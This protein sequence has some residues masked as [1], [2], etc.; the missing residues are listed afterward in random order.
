[1]SPPP[2]SFPL[3]KSFQNELYLISEAGVRVINIVSHEWERVRACLLELRAKGLHKNKPIIGWSPSKGIYLIEQGR[4][5]LERFAD[6]TA[7]GNTNILEI[8]N[9]DKYS[10][11]DAIWLLEDIH[12]HL[13]EEHINILSHLKNLARERNSCH[14]LIIINT[15]FANLPPEVRKDVPT[16]ELPLPRQGVLKAIL[17]SVLNK[18]DHELPD[19]WE[20]IVDAASGLTVMEAELAFAKVNVE[21]PGLHQSA[22]LSKIAHEKSRVIKQTQI[23]EFFQTET[24]LSQD[25]GGLENLKVWLKKRQ[26]S[27]S[28][29]AK[30]LGIEAPKGIMLLG[31]QGC[32]KSLIAK[33]I[34]KEWS[35]PLLR[36]DLG[37]VFGGI[38][39]QSEG[40]IRS[41]LQVAAA[42]EP[43]VLWID[44]IEK[45]LAG[46]GS[47][48]RSDGGTTAR[49]VGTLLTWMQE[50]KEQV[51]VVATANRID[52]LPPELLR[53][54]RFDEI[55]FVDLPTKSVRRE[56]L[57]I[58]LQKRDKLDK[59]TE[60]KLDEL[61]EQTRGFSGAELEE[62][63]REALLDWY[64]DLP[65][66]KP[67]YNY[68]SHVAQQTNPLSVLMSDQIQDLRKWAGQ[69]TRAASEGEP[70]DPPKKSERPLLTPSESAQNRFFRPNS[71]QPN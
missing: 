39:G 64:A 21:H 33:A 6:S 11:L 18:S 44:E 4:E 62:M 56:I 48:D 35:Y 10:N 19:N 50:K 7:V 65:K 13:R 25:V 31:V 55:F 57:K 29:Q 15:P 12:G 69:R 45:G 20:S 26:S 9:S 49:V 5:N 1:M 38:V 68:L 2:D 58:H 60:S 23:L 32:G 3:D 24:N 54:G 70:E 66:S 27:F 34:A 22:V 61:A 63:V 28:Y 36:F 67:L 59:A 14:R 8:I 51:F 46:M 42:L 41:A 30:Q 37:K 52:M 53:K 43:C 47:S 71:D 17:Q 16:L 40:N